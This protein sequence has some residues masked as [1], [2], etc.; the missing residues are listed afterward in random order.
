MFRLNITNLGYTQYFIPELI[1][2]DQLC[3]LHWSACC[4][5][6]QNMHSVM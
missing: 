2:V 3:P 6:F 1:N 5:M 4:F